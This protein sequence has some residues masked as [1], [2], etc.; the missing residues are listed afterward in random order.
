V[1]LMSRPLA[2][3]DHGDPPFGRSLVLGTLRVLWNAVR[4]PMLALL[5]ILEPLVTLILSAMAFV[6]VVAACVL[7][8]SGDLPH[9]PFWGMMGFSVVC[10][11]LLMAYHALLR[12][13]SR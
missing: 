6:G 7:R 4:L 12:L 11:L 5:I 1:H 13:L 8:L 2:T 9:F 10:M 3:L